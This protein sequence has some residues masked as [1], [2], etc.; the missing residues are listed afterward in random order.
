MTEGNKGP[1][2]ERNLGENRPI[3]RRDFI[4]GAL[5]G[6]ATALTGPLL[7]AYAAD[8]VDFGA[9]AQGRPGYYPPLLNGMRGSH[10]GS[11]ESAHA[12]RDGTKPGA[13]LD[14][15]EVYDLVVVGGGISGLSAAH[16]YRAQTSSRTR[17]LILDNHDDFGGHAKRNEFQIGGRTLLLNGGTLEIDSPRPY[18]AAAAGLIK[19]LGIDVAALKK[20][21][22]PE[23]YSGL[24][25]QRGVFFDKETF[26]ADQLV[27]GAGVVPAAKLLAGSPFSQRAR[28]DY[29]RLNEG[30]ID[31]L[32]GLSCD[33]KKLTLSKLSYRDFL[34]DVAKVDPAVI[35][36]YQPRSHGEW[37]VG[38]D[39]VSA[40]DVWAFGFP[41]FQGM[42]LAPGV[43]SRMGYTPSGYA[44]TG[45]SETLHFPDGNA[46]IAR[47]LV[48]NLVP[49]AVPGNSVEDIVTARV[50][51]GRLDRPDSP[52]R[53]RL[54][55]TVIRASNVGDPATAREVVVIYLRDGKAYKVR[56]RGCV[57][58]SYNAM[59]PYLCPDLPEKQQ[60]ALHGAVKAPLVYT[61][62]ALRNWQAFKKLGIADV[63][64]PGSYHSSFALNPKVDIGDY[65]SPSSPDDP[66]LIR[67]LRVPTQPGLTEHEQN[68]AGR[69]ELLATPFATFERNIRDQLARTLGAGGFDPARDIAAITVNRWPHGYAAEFNPLFEP[70]LPPAEQRQV[71]SRAQFGRI[72]IANS[73]AGAAAYTDSA[74]DQA[75]RAVG[76]LLRTDT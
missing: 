25:L 2:I 64:A 20:V 67:M 36:F 5:V 42:K 44:A 26:G 29:V 9:G 7:K 69:A 19:E 16:F 30:A 51:Y 10:P 43:I 58:A 50:D 21:E 57:L 72:T 60:A 68:K 56:A 76:E 45:G 17:I 14:T 22:H 8:S 49:G 41:G 62:V 54:N 61:S 31:Y 47:L 24:G 27:V 28:Q 23:F 70:E 38:I 75:Y 37:A 71:V 63:Y 15:G 18:D 48:R 35:A 1:P 55:S 66:I 59:I 11:F 53:L 73:D 13:G 39:A 6:A 40:L 46:T 4:Q 3:P 65:R 32:P 52:V 33:E 74:I 12:L 34:R